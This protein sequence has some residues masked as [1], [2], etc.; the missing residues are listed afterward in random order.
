RTRAHRRALG[1]AIVAGIVAALA[2][3]ALSG[4]AGWFL[5]GAGLAA[6]AGLGASFNYL[7]PS[8]LIRQSAILR[9]GARYFER[10]LSHRAAL[11]A[12][13]DL[14]ADLFGALAGIAPARALAL[15]GGEAAARF[16]EDVD[17]L[18][19]RVV[20]SP[21]GPAAL[22]AGLAAIAVAALVS[23]LAALVVALGLGGLAPAV[24]LAGRRW[25]DR[26]AE[27]VQ[28]RIGDLK[29]A[30]V[31]QVEAAVEV[32]ML[33]L[34]ERAAAA[35]DAEAARLDSARVRM[36]AIDSGLAGATTALAAILAGAVLILGQGAPIPLAAGAALAAFAAAEAQ[37]GIVRAAIEES[38]IRAGL[39]RL[40]VEAHDP[41]DSEAP[42]EPEA[43]GPA[44]DLLFAT[45]EARGAGRAR[46]VVPP[47]GRLL[48]AGRSGSGK[49]RTL[50]ALAGLSD[51]PAAP[52]RIGATPLAAIPPQARMA[53]FALAPQ[54][55]TLIA[56]TL[57]DNLAIARP[58]LS[59]EAMWE[60]LDIACLG[61]TVR[62]RAGGLDAL[63]GDA[64]AGLSGGEAKRLAI[65]RALLA[66][67]PWL[68]LDEPSEGLDAATEAALVANLDSWLRRTGT[69]L[70]LVSHRR[71]PQ[72]LASQRLDLS[73][74]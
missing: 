45:G 1:W 69:G 29:A 16:V 65:A 5:A 4:L 39:G 60:A 67:R 26:A 43:S 63:L 20:R 70:I 15:S 48:L 52:I 31:A 38:R 59:R 23:P 51:A 49:T 68:L 2:A 37:G 13:A 9:T 72:A 35:L 21:A 32:R 25:H 19:N 22:A 54:A 17:A 11:L 24:R 36:A 61:E 64:G 40:A 6:L 50:L 53:H 55:P 44:G 42:G 8:A 47:G 28:A 3:V 46:L 14:R 30:T 12:L 58:G 41:A 33:G 34:A 7:L 71:A 27:A 73:P 10:L 62:A 74:A 18:E 56:G 57:A 66:G